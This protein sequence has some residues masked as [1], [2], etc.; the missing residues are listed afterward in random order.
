VHACLF[1]EPEIFL[2]LLIV[3]NKPLKIDM[4]AHNLT[5]LNEYCW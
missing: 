5:F 1:C 4:M 2:I 3:C